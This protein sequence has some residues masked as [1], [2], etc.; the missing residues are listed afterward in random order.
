MSPAKIAKTL[1]ASWHKCIN[2]SSVAGILILTVRSSEEEYCNS[3][4]I[5]LYV[6]SPALLRMMSRVSYTSASKTE[7]K[8]GV[9][10]FETWALPSWDQTWDEI[11]ID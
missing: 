10:E 5:M 8:L 7:H 6:T 11:Q 2:S 1:I 4:D 9:A 3:E